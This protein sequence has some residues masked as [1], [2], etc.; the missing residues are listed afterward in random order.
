MN[1]I[2]LTSNK[3]PENYKFEKNRKIIFKYKF[4]LYFCFF[5]IIICTII[6]IINR[7]NS[8]KQEKLSK[9]LLK[10]YT[11]S[12]LYANSININSNII[13][14]STI[15]ND[16]FM[17]G[18]IEIKKIDIMYPIL[19]ETNEELLKIAPCRFIRSYAK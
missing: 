15:E 14:N 11:I 9:A 13:S 16:P 1:Q 18:L 19:S 10:N 8:N 2:I 5:I 3:T 17:I 7:Y 4:L 12:K 6:Y